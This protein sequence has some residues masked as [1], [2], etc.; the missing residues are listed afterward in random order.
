MCSLVQCKQCKKP[1]WA[2]C[3]NHIEAALAGIPEVDRCHCREEKKGAASGS[4]G[5][6][7]GFWTRLFGNTE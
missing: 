6:S 7:G 5:S 2:G 4:G 3:G 1:T